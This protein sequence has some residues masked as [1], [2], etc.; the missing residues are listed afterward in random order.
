LPVQNLKINEIM[1]DE[2]GALVSVIVGHYPH[3]L[4]DPFFAFWYIFGEF[5]IFI[6]AYGLIITIIATLIRFMTK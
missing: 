6:W 1:P 4:V 5:Y 3:F 2:L